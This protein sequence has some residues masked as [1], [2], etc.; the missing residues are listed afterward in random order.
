MI[1]VTNGAHHKAVSFPFVIQTGN[2]RPWQPA[3]PHMVPLLLQGWCRLGA[4]PA[5]SVSLTYSSKGPRRH[6]HSQP[7]RPQAPWPASRDCRN[8][9]PPPVSPLFFY[10]PSSPPQHTLLSPSQAGFSG[11]PA[12]IP[13]GPLPM[14]SSA[15]CSTLP[16]P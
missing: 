1:C 15:P 14:N 9:A 6:C 16:S 12:L 7:D 10:L 4:Q 8:L 13:P 5:S 2:Q 11:F 3:Q